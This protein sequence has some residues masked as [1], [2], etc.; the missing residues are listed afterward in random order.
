MKKTNGRLRC[1]YAGPE[2][3]ARKNGETPDEN[4][5]NGSEAERPPYPDSF[6]ENEDEQPMECVYAGPSM[7]EFL[8]SD[9]PMS[10]TVYAAPSIKAGGREPL[11]QSVYACPKPPP[12]S[13][14]P[15]MRLVYAG[16]EYFRKQ[17]PTMAPL[18]AAPV[19]DRPA[20]APD[21]AMSEVYAGPELMERGD[22]PLQER[23]SE[24]PSCGF[25][26]IASAKFCQNCGEK[27]GLCRICTSCG[28]K[29]SEGANFC[30][31]CGA[32]IPELEPRTKA[33]HIRKGF[34]ARPKG[35][36]D[37]LV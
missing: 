13:D 21:A 36:R 31:E 30:I 3:F 16:P 26:N 9:D 28:A 23:V 10:S 1:V 17:R 8:D 12:V 11:M 27:L 33:P 4:G 14:K 22:A 20:Q 24:C 37:E 15:Q 5:G 18:Y 7:G 35:T 2:F 19:I 6:K 25:T 29:V 34:I 32:S